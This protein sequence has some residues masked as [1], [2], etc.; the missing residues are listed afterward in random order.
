MMTIAAARRQR[1]FTLIEIIAALVL[2]GILAATVFNF[3]GQAV[4][5]FF[6]ARDAL[7]ITQKAQIAMN[8]MRIEFTYLASVSASSSTSITYTAEFPSGTETHTI[9]TA[10]GQL[11]YDGV[12]LVDGVGGCTF[13]YYD[14]PSAAADTS[15]DATNTKLIGIT[16]TMQDSDGVTATFTTRVAPGKI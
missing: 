14:D 11:T 1:G 16:L 15:F 13:A 5:G 10:A 12:A 8:R 4:R 3:M 2:M 9:T 6:I 7:A